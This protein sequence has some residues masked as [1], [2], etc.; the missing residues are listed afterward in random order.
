MV[1]ENQW[2][3]CNMTITAGDFISTY[4]GV[5]GGWRRVVN[6]NFSAGD[7]FPGEWTK[8]THS[9]ISFCM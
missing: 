4:T 9:N 6:V 7:D 2:T 8:A 1:N 5:G 3:Y